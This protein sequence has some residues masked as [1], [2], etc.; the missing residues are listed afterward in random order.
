MKQDS[1]LYWIIYFIV[2]VIVAWIA[3][4]LILLWFRPAVYN[5]DGTVNWWNTLWVSAL[6]ILFAW[7]IMI[8]ITFLIRAFTV[9]PC[10]PCADQFE[11]RMW[12]Y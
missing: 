3:F 8:I 6:V 10:D 2:T 5:T 1:I 11:P 9:N 7:L 12:M 4:S